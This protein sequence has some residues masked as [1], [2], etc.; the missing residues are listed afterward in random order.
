V[1]PV[2]LHASERLPRTPDHVRRR[3]KL[4][5]LG[6]RIVTNAFL[7]CYVCNM[8]PRTGKEPPASPSRPR[9]APRLE[10]GFDMFRWEDRGAG[11]ARDMRRFTRNAVS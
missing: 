3:A 6:N 8:A 11:Y 1:T 4:R 7:H 9:S 10:E 2:R 5:A